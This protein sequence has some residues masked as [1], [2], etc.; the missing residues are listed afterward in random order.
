MLSYWLERN[1]GD[2]NDGPNYA[3]VGL[4]RFTPDTDNPVDVEIEKEISGLIE[5]WGGDGRVFRDCKY[6]YGELKGMVKDDTL[7]SD[8][9]RLCK[10]HDFT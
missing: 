4:G 10:W 2:W 1:R 3:E 6:N 9:N 7:V 8:L 5:D